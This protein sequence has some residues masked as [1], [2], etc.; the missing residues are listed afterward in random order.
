M[1]ICR[2]E[3]AARAL[4]V[5]VVSVA[6]TG[7]ALTPDGTSEEM[8]RI[9]RQG[10]RYEPGIEERSLPELP[11]QATWEDVLRRA[12]LANGELEAAYFDWKAAAERIEVASAWP[13]SRLMLGYSYT[14]SGG[15]MKGFDRNSF[16]FSPDSMESLL[17]PTKAAQQGKVALDEARAAGARFRA[18]KFD[19]QRRVL[20]AWAEFGLLAEKARIER[21]RRSLAQLTFE[22]ARSRL[23]GGGMQQDLLRAEVEVRVADDTVRAI[24]AE[25]ASARA[26]LNSMLARAPDAP[27]AAPTPMQPPREIAADDAA[28][29]QAAVDLN[30]ELEVLAHQTAGRADALELAKMQWLPDINPTF[31]F[32]GSASQ[33]IGAAIMLPTTIKEI[34]G[35]IKEAGANLRGSEAMLRQA[36]RDR[37]GLFVATLV[38]LR[39]AERQAALFSGNIVPA[40]ERIAAISRQSYSAGM[41]GYLDMIEAERTLLA[42]RLTAA[43]ARAVREKRLAEIEALMGVDIET[44]ADLGAGATSGVPFA[45]SHKPGVH[46]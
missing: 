16:S 8:S 23:L 29:L 15:N 39:D 44:I 2:A 35:G 24:E 40:A 21:E 3:A 4:A 46:P 33:A 11:A 12:F 20:V 5:I 14:F 10:G 36:R 6:T 37:E 31:A 7:C 32:T 19:L 34:E 25:L 17:W 26:L 43:E 30:P 41:V 18:A 38:S 1:F 13:N 45:A 28:L 9:A 22:T 42:S 27:L